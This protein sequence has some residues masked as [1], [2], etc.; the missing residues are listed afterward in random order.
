MICE[1]PPTD[2]LRRDG[3][4]NEENV[5]YAFCGAVGPHIWMMST[6]TI[7]LT[8]EADKNMIVVSVGNLGGDAC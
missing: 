5:L 8:A 6:N 7:L 2:Y 4:P 3:R 1:E